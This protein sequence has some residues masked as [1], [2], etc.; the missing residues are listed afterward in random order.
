MAARAFTLVE[1]LVVLMILG[2][3]MAMLAPTLAKAIGIARRRACAGNES[4]IVKAAGQYALGD[5]KK[6]L[7]TVFG[8]NRTTLSGPNQGYATWADMKKGQP[9]CLWL[10]VSEKQADRS[11]FLC[12]EAANNRSW[13]APTLDANAFTYVPLTG[14]ATTDISSLSYSFISMTYHV[15]SGGWMTTPVAPAI[16]SPDELGD[17]MCMDSVPG[18]LIVLADQNPRCTF[19]VSTSLQTYD[20]LNSAAGGKLSIRARRSSLNHHREGQ[21]I[22]RWDGACSWVLDSNDQ[23][24]ND[25]YSSSM[26]GA[27]EKEG[28]R[29]EMA[30]PFVLP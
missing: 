17:Q 11:V 28:R 4:V 9:A 2:L 19:G 29:K 30:D 7:P 14:G 27:G 22:T 25:V 3:L 26:T 15:G 24:G 10:L 16:A 5:R 13:V 8:Y 12:P 23:S 6:C 1:L 18:T 21:N 20:Q